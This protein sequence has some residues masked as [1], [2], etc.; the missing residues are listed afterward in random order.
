MAEGLSRVEVTKLAAVLGAP[1]ESLDFLA[2]LPVADVR[3]FRETVSDAIV[4]RHETRLRLLASLSQR[5][6]AAVAARI[7]QKAMGPTLAGRIAGALEPPDAAALA[8]HLDRD[9]L[10]ALTPALDPRVVPGM[11]E[12]LPDELLIDVGRR[13]LASGDFLTLGRFVSVVA[14]ETALAV[15]GTAAPADLLRTVVYTD[16]SAASRALLERLPAATVGAVATAAR[17]AGVH[18]ELTASGALP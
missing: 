2:A 8:E 1:E 16:S 15:L 7:A 5:M 9:F 11:I 17:E 18:E 10:A 4:A 3:R 13:L 12:Q 14:P 6:P